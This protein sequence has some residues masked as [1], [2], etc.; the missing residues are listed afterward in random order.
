MLSVKLC[1][2]CPGPVT[3]TCSP[4]PA[5]RAGS[6]SRSCR[7]AA[8][9]GVGGDRAAQ[10]GQRRSSRRRTVESRLPALLQL[11][12]LIVR[13][14][15]PVASRMPV[16]L[17]VRLAGLMVMV[18][19][20]TCVEISPLLVSAMA[21][22]ESFGRRRSGRPAESPA[23]CGSR[24]WADGERARRPVHLH[25]PRA[26]RRPLEQDRAGERL[27]R[28]KA[29]VGLAFGQMRRREGRAAGDLGPR[30]GCCSG[31]VPVDRHARQTGW[32]CWRR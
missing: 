9:S 21:P 27:S 28:R 26:G 19:P 29:Q 6:A 22:P 10:V 25:R 24:P 23:W 12:E 13:M 14:P 20:L 7:H 3:V 32:R 18:R 5:Q 4:S 11:V 1:R 15:P 16:A 30:A 8:S 17:L 2:R 31:Q